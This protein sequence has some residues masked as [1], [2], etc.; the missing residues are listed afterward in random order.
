VGKNTNGLYKK[1]KKD[2]LGKLEHLD[3]K[4]EST[5]LLPHEI[6]LKQCLNARLIQLL[7]E[8]EIK[9]YQRVKSNKLLQGDI[10]T[11]YF[12]MVANGK[13]KKSQIFELSDGHRTI[14]GNKPLKSY[15]MD[16]YKNLLGPSNGGHFSLEEDRRSDIA[17]ISPEDNENLTSIFTEQEVKEAIFQMK[18]NKAPGPDSF[19]A[20]FYQIF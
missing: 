11:K 18:H 7:R 13:H 12:H 15:I 14:R 5:L 17:Q 1:E 6:N 10:N 9:W 16:Y 2:T 8:E 20:H 19:L 3:K 4:A